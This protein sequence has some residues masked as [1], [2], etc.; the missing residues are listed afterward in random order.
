MEEKYGHERLTREVHLDRATRG[1]DDT[2]IRI[3]LRSSANA[4]DGR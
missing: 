2:R 1:D 4:G 3:R